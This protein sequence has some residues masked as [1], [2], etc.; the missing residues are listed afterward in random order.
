PRRTDPAGPASP[1][2]R[3]VATRSP[4]P[5]SSPRRRI[6]GNFLEAL[7]SPAYLSLQPPAAPARRVDVRPLPTPTRTM[8]HRKPSRRPSRPFAPRVEGLEDRSVPAGNVTAF[9]SG[10]GLYL[11]G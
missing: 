4:G 10:G 5:A 6:T 3:S 8:S 9:A 2:S 1:P 7:V 11:F